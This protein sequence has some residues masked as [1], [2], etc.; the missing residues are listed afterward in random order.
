MVG[1]VNEARACLLVMPGSPALVRELAPAD[2]PS[3]RLLNSIRETAGKLTKTIDIVCSH[4]RRW[5]THLAGS[6]AAWGAPHVEVRGGH[7]LGELVAR[8]CLHGATVRESREHLLPLDPSVLTV[9]VVD[10]PAGLTT[11]APLALIPAAADTHD[12]LQALL[13]GK[14]SSLIREQEMRDAGVLEP[15]IWLELQTLQPTNATLVDVDD[16]LGVGRYV[17][18]WEVEQ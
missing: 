18:Y 5:T 17:A 15:D 7:V 2:E 13:S 1:E 9:L 8:Y 4:D 12:K 16:T 10:G 14:Q 3:Q 11:R 6:F